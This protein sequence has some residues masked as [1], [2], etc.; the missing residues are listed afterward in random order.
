[1]IRIL[2]LVVLSTLL[3]ACAAFGPARMVD[4]E[5][6]ETGYL[7]S[8]NVLASPAELNAFLIGQDVKQV[9]LVRSPDATSARM[10]DTT[11]ALRDAGVTIVE[12]K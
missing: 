7:V 3:S 12:T 8:N 2:P 11:T 6:L 9:R 5:V 10:S 4:V 1:M